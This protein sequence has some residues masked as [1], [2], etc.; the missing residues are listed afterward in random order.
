MGPGRQAGPHQPGDEVSGGG[1]VVTA[2]PGGQGGHGGA[3]EVERTAVGG[4]GVQRAQSGLPELDR[5]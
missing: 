3:V 5:E 4:V 1:T 2:H